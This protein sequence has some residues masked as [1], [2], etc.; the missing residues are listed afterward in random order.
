MKIDTESAFF[1][2][3]ADEA[4]D[5][6]WPTRAD[7]FSATESIDEAGWVPH[8]LADEWEYDEA[9]DEYDEADD[10]YDEA[11]DEYYE[12]DDETTSTRIL[13]RRA[14]T[15]KTTANSGAIL[16]AGTKQPGGLMNS[17]SHPPTTNALVATRWPFWNRRTKRPRA[18][19]RGANSVRVRRF[20]MT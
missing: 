4:T 8:E 2:S 10:E 18:G 19:L 7:V 13:V 1:A 20:R 14:Q 12:T 15:K 17:M 6:E 3:L 16:K 9:D 5:Y 11:D